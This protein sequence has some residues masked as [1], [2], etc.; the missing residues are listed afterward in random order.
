MYHLDTIITF[1]M[2]PV[3]GIDDPDLIR[4]GESDDP[5]VILGIATISVPDFADQA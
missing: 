4:F 3:Y 5:C 2:L 1:E